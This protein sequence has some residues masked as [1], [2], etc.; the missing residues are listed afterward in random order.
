MKGR[1]LDRAQRAVVIV[2]LGAVFIALGQF[3]TGLGSNL[4][5]GW[6]AYAPL[7]NQ[8]NFDRLHPWVRLLIWIALTVTWVAASVK[9]L[10]PSSRS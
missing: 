5:S 10:S 2:G 6:V 9:L 8:Y 1:A 7:S 4:P 3:L